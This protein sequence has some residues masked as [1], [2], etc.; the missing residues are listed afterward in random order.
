MFFCKTV[1]IGNNT[2]DLLRT[3]GFQNLTKVFGY[4][5]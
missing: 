3:L 2:L 1:D 5:I 4:N